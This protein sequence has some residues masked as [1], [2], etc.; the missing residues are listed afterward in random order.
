MNEFE[1]FSPDSRVWIYAS[2]KPL[3]ETQ[4]TALESEAK[5]FAAT[6]TA[7]QLP[8]KADAK[9]IDNLFLVFCVDENQHEV[10]GC[11][12]DKSVDFMRKA[13]EKLQVDFFNRTQIEIQQNGIFQIM[14][15][16]AI[17]ELLNTNQLSAQSLFADKTITD[18]QNFR[19]HFAKPITQAWFFGR[20]NLVVSKTDV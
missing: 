10:S 17:N 19:T 20:L 5:A 1:N 9:M 13:G 2:S 7:H 6:W 12:I 8:L 4:A 11:G 18:L 15:L 16:S 3:S 14:S